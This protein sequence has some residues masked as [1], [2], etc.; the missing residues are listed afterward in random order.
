MRRSDFRLNRHFARQIT[1]AC[2]FLTPANLIGAQPNVVVE[3]EEVVTHYTQADNGAGPMWCYGSTVVARD[4]DDVFVST[5]ETG[6]DVPPLC[7]CRWQLWHRGGDGW[8]LMQ[9]E[10]NYRQREPCP[11]AVIPGGPVFLSV[12]PSTEPPGVQYG[13]CQPLV[14]QFDRNKLSAPPRKNTPAFAEGTH[15]TDHSYRGFGA[16]GETGELLLLNVNARTAKYFVSQR[17]AGGVWHARGTITFPI[18]GAYPQVSLRRGAAHVL[19]I[20][21]IVEPVEEW[22]KLKA[23]KTGSKWDYVFRRLFYTHT[24]S[25]E[26][27]PF[28]EPLEVDTVEKTG[29]HIANLDLFVD[30]AGAAHLLYLKRPH[31]NAVIREKYFPQSADTAHLEYAIVKDGNVV[32]RRTLAE[33][34]RTTGGLTPGYARFHVADGE[35]PY[36]V[37]NGTMTGRDGKSFTDMFLADLTIE[38]DKPMFQRLNVKT[39]LSNFF[40]NTPRGGSKP[41]NIID[42]FGVGGA[43]QLALRYVRVRL[44]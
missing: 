36:V 35:K 29:G 6:K 12:N 13:P 33:T 39:P 40:T 24:P 44:K 7:N 31:A 38:T 1:A 30:A 4:G 10:E 26:N 9:H 21:N 25:I 43:D 27:K 19:A 18:R 42:L 5:I 28:A 41:G 3:A 32:S 15:F 16:D 37:A 34:T 8:K 17:D 14:L 23:E 11:I 20:G 2:L 22:Q